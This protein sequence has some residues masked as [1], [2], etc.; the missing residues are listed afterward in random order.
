MADM[1]QTGPASARLADRSTDWQIDYADMQRDAF[2]NL[3]RMAPVERDMA[4]VEL[5]AARYATRMQILDQN[6]SE[7]PWLSGEDFG[8]GEI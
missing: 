6:V 3:V 1:W 2:A 8:I 4:A 5:S 7:M